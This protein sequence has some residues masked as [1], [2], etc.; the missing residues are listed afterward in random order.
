[1]IINDNGSNSQN[2]KKQ[3]FYNT[4]R[5]ILEKKDFFDSIVRGK[6]K[7]RSEESLLR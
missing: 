6:G 4:D 5:V 3:S 1:M 2:V 7:K